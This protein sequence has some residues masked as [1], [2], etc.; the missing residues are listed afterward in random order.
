MWS[1]EATTNCGTDVEALRHIG[2]R[3][4]EF[5]DATAIDWR[6]DTGRRHLS[7][8]IRI[9]RPCAWLWLL[10]VAV[11][12]VP[13]AAHAALGLELDYSGWIEPA[14]S[15]L[16]SVFVLGVSITTIGRGLSESGRFASEYLFAVCRMRDFWGIT[17]AGVLLAFAA[18]IGVE[19]D[20]L[21]A[22]VRSGLATC[23]VGAT[24]GCICVLGFV[25]LE[26]I[27]CS[28][29]KGAVQAATEYASRTLCHAFLRSAYIGAFNEAHKR[30]I[31]MWCKNNA[32]A[33]KPPSQYWRHIHSSDYADAGGEF[34]EGDIV[35]DSDFDI[36][37]GY[38]DFELEGLRKIDEFLQERE[39]ELYLAPH[40]VAWDKPNVGKIRVKKEDFETVNYKVKELARLSCKFRRD[41]FKEVGHDFWKSNFLKLET[42]LAK[43]IGSADWDQF[44]AYMR[45]IGKPLKVLRDIWRY[46]IVRKTSIQTEIKCYDIMNLYVR[47][48]KRISQ[49][50]SMPEVSEQVVTEFSQILREQIWSEVKGA[51][52]AGDWQTLKLF[53]EVIPR[54]YG[55][56]C[57]TSSIRGSWLWEE[58]A[59][60]GQFYTFT[61]GLFEEAGLDEQIETKLRRI[62]HDGITRWL[63]VALDQADSELAGPLCSSARNVVMRK[64]ELKF[65]KTGLMGCHFVLAGWILSKALDG[66]LVGAEDI[67][68][69]FFSRRPQRKDLNFNE[70]ADF[71]TKFKFPHDLLRDYVDILKPIPMT[72]VN[73]LSGARHGSGTGSWGTFEAALAFVYLSGF[74][75]QQLT[76]GDV[77]VLAVDLTGHPLEP[78]IKRLKDSQD[79]RKIYRHAHPSMF[80]SLEKWIQDCKKAYEQERQQELA[81]AQLDKERVS[82][83]IR[84]FWCGYREAI[85]FLSYCAR[86][87]RISIDDSAKQRIKYT[88]S[89]EPFAEKRQGG[90]SGLGNSDGE[91][92]GQA[93]E[94]Q[95]LCQLCGL[96]EEQDTNSG[97]EDEDS[98]ANLEEEQ[99][100]KIRRSV[101][102]AREW[103]KG[104]GRSANNGAIVFV[105]RVH[106]ESV[107]DTDEG[108]IPA[109]REEHGAFG[110]VGLYGDFP[111]VWLEESASSTYCVALDFLGW[112][113]VHVRAELLRDESYGKVDVVKVT[114]DEIDK[115]VQEGKLKNEQRN[116]ALGTCWV[117]G[118]LYW[119]FK[120]EELP[121]R[122]FFGAVEGDVSIDNGPIT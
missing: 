75:W 77:N 42:A 7:W 32:S 5:K 44:A 60:F 18:L 38:M 56:V 101:K 35:I 111:L 93:G 19:L 45:S 79:G 24:I 67:S 83:F 90:T 58:R 39:A 8:E 21:P 70:L 110:F 100:G 78:A 64:E 9:L 106:P 16:V 80:N 103:L 105:G 33:I 87:G 113:G 98:E 121:R 59:K 85:P 40:G 84:E 49:E 95:L 109:W 115:A 10:L 23:V 122:R 82:S 22:F 14:L 15:V 57:E 51:V 17:F 52:V 37:K 99:A 108:F 94:H 102:E 13:G 81:E 27:R 91:W 104:R 92:V 112:T 2:E 62:L 114:Q 50:A 47:A 120:G 73:P 3:V 65:E 86:N 12:F 72:E 6:E 69:L 30:T 117:T 97:E 41:R 55:V 31:E 1:S 68:Q 28:V 119:A 20:W 89:K 25:M 61:E 107:L 34:E 36:H 116:Q 43:A 88:V 63:T 48:L 11:F 29:P 53:T 71:Y 54:M 76:Q 4:G 46:E 96:G 118:E 66:K 74:A 26:T